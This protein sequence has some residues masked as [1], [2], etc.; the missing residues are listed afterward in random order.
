ML[1]K[2]SGNDAL[3]IFIVVFQWNEVQSCVQTSTYATILKIV[4]NTNLFGN[5]RK[6]FYFEN[7]LTK[8]I[9]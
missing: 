2:V 5:I 9:K 3:A 1:E 8:Y 4:L 6:H 7:G